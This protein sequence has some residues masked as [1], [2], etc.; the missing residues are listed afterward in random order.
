MN[1]KR[2]FGALLTV[3]G[4][5]GLIYTAIL[6]AN[7]ST[8]IRDIKPLITYGLLGIIFFMSGISLVRTTKDES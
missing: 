2:L 1:I 5:G 3:L 4:I 7:A 6:F 8:E